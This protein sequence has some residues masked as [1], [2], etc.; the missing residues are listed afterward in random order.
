M[1]DK[2]TIVNEMVENTTD[3]MEE[4]AQF[5][6]CVADQYVEKGDTIRAEHWSGEA[7]AIMEVVKFI[8]ERGGCWA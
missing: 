5:C 1:K 2:N 8:R 4:K 7:Q 6:Q 3:I